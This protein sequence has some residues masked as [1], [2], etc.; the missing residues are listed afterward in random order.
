MGDRLYEAV[1]RISGLGALAMFYERR[2][3]KPYGVEIKTFEEIAWLA[4]Q[5]QA[6]L[7]RGDSRQRS[8]CGG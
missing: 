2:A 8:Q 5:L 1:C 3:V 4:V 7:L 6:I